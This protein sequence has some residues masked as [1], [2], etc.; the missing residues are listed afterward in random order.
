[1][2]QSFCVLVSPAVIHD[3]DG[4]SL[5]FCQDDGFCD[6]RSEMS[7]GDKVDVVGFLILQFQKDLCQTFGGDV[8]TVVP[9]GNLCVLTVDTP[10]ITSRKKNRACS[11]F[12]GQARFFPHV[13]RSPGSGQIGSLM[14]VADLSV[15]AVYAAVSGTQGTAFQ[16]V[17][18]VCVHISCLYLSENFFKYRELIK[19]GEVISRC[20][21]A[22]DHLETAIFF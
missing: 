14:T 3:R 10:Q 8:R 22:A 12:A 6:H 5:F 4:E 7:W 13:Q 11:F 18:P 1:M 17:M 9:V 16:H 21:C 19:G 20:L 2:S 15:P